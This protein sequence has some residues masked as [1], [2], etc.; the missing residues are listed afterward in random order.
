MKIFSNILFARVRLCVCRNRNTLAV[1]FKMKNKEGRKM[2]FSFFSVI[3]YNAILYYFQFLG[4]KTLL[5]YTDSRSGKVTWQN[6]DL[7]IIYTYINYVDYYKCIYHII[8]QCTLIWLTYGLDQS[9]NGWLSYVLQWYLFH[10]I[11]ETFVIG[12]VDTYL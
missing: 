10:S 1:E 3:G 8:E 5:S 11:L 6:T 12:K 2:F 7:N 4:T 9:L